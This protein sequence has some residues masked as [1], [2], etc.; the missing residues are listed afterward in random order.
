MQLELVLKLLGILGVLLA[1]LAQLVQ[2]FRVL[3]RVE[4]FVEDLFQV[5]LIAEGP[6]RLVLVAEDDVFE[7]GV[8]HAEEHGHE[9]VHLGAIM[10]HTNGLTTLVRALQHLLHLFELLLILPVE[11]LV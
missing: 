8:A 2:R 11:Q 4:D 3:G 1:D 10:G 7:D 9:L 5:S 6:I